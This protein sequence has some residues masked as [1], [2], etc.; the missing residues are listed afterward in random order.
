M[1]YMFLLKADAWARELNHLGIEENFKR[2]IVW[3]F[4]YIQYSR[5]VTD[6]YGI[7]MCINTCVAENI[8]ICHAYLLSVEIMYNTCS[9]CEI[10][11]ITLSTWR[12]VACM[13]ILYRA[14][15][16]N[17]YS[18]PLTFQ[19]TGKNLSHSSYLTTQ[20]PPFSSSKPQADT[21]YPQAPHVKHSW[22]LNRYQSRWNLPAAMGPWAH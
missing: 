20:H 13:Y 18:I 9:L 21:C 11:L 7:Y 15:I 3:L 12:R 22:L 16:L 19:D 4:V 10:R 6:L 17:L 2:H 14:T 5:W 8:K 1:V